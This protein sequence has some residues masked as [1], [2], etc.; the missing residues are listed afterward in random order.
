[1]LRL[2]VQV[3]GVWSGSVGVLS[4][5][6]Q[7]EGKIGGAS[8]GEATAEDGNEVLASEG[9]RHEIPSLPRSGVAAEC[10]LHQRRRVEFGFHGFHQVFGGVLRAAQARFFFFHFADFT[11][12][13]VTRGFGKGIEEFLE[14]FG[15][16]E[17]AGKNGVDWHGGRRT[18]P[19]MRRMERIFTDELERRLGADGVSS[20]SLQVAYCGPDEPVYRTNGKKQDNHDDQFRKPNHPIEHSG[21]HYTPR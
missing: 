6:L 2:Y 19:R 8:V 12:D 4:G 14:A 16:A 10:S 5:I 11:V 3:F 18:L 9:L 1:V 20:G 17:F 15:L 7:G 13:L 21:S